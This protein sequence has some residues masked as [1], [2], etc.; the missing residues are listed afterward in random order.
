MISI[1][2]SVFAGSS[3]LT[4]LPVLMLCLHLTSLGAGKKQLSLLVVIPS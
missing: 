4:D 3:E 2:E 1:E